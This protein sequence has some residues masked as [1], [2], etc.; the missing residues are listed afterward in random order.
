MKFGSQVFY[1]HAGEWYGLKDFVNVFDL[2]SSRVY[3]SAESSEPSAAKVDATAPTQTQDLAATSSEAAATDD[4]NVTGSD[5]RTSRDETTKSTAKSAE[6]ASSGKNSGSGAHTD[7]KKPASSPEVKKAAVD[8]TKKQ[9]TVAKKA[10][11]KAG[12]PV[13]KKKANATPK[14]EGDS[15]KKSVRKKAVVG[16]AKGKPDPPTG[17]GGAL[18]S[19]GAKS[20]FQKLTNKSS[21]RAFLYLDNAAFSLWPLCTL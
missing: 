21:F 1:A 16:D 13:E 5:R 2:L 18:A 17:I 20:I 6:A 14:Q 19:S 12:K 15:S 3:F 9:H 11:K 8:S 7:A 4:K 10:N